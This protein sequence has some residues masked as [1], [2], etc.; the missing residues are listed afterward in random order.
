MN[1]IKLVCVLSF[2]LSIAACEYITE[3]EN[4]S[5][6]TVTVLAPKNDTVIDSIAIFT[7]EALD[8]AENYHVQVA[9]PS[10][11]N[12]SQIVVDTLVVKTSYSKALTTGSYEWRVNAENSEYKTVYSTQN[13]SV[14]N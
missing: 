9:K 11:E 8:D 2:V 12:A 13:F 1:K 4:I 3:V 7:W 14:S 6:K 10:F 5:E